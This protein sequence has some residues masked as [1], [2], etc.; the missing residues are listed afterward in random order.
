MDGNRRYAKRLGLD[1]IKGHSRGFEKLAQTLQW[2]HDLG[3]TEVTVYA[4]SI[5][6]FKR[7]QAE[8]DAL[9]KLAQEKFERLIEEKDRLAEQG[10]RVNV[11][12]I[13]V[14]YPL[15]CNFWLKKPRR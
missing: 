5:E 2:C 1:K 4:F 8:V 14:F 12:G 3:I 10:V 9:L 11:I 15:I 6:N 13:S 7:P